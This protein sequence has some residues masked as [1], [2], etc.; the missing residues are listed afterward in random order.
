MGPLCFCPSDRTLAQDRKSCV[1][2]EIPNEGKLRV[3][4]IVAGVVGLVLV[5]VIIFV[6]CKYRQTKVQSFYKIEHRGWLVR[7]VVVHALSQS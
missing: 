7:L 6:T 4:L 1:V 2:L 3:G 5:V